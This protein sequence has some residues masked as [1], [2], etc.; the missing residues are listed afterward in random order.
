MKR[1]I[2][3]GLMCLATTANANTVTDVFTSFYSFGD[4][5]TDQGMFGTLPATPPSVGGRFTNGPTWA[6]NIAEVFEDAGR[7]T[8]NLAVGGA[9]AGNGGTFT[10]LSNFNGQIDTFLGSLAGGVPLPTQIFPV[11]ELEDTPAA[12]G[13]NPLVSV[14]LG[15]NDLFAGLDVPDILASIAGGGIGFD[16]AVVTD[17]ADAVVAGI[18]R[19]ATAPGSVFDDFLVANLPDLGATPAYA[20][21]LALN[22]FDTRTVAAISGAATLAT[23]MF[24]TALADNLDTLES[25]LDINLFEY[26][27]AAAF[28]EVI[29]DP[30]AFGFVS[31]TEPC[32]VSLNSATNPFVCDPSEVDLLVF[33]DAVHPNQV[34]QRLTSDRILVQLNAATA[35]A[36]V[37]LPASAPLLLLGAGALIAARR[38]KAA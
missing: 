9:T 23:D 38:R 22:G 11:V 33:I 26:D 15:A 19:L 27:A 12:P 17:A 34:A 32:T 31:A 28:A 10:P 24:N 14:W 5:L 2:A 21:L 20:S 29:A 37:P 30:S 13:S 8:G 4:S 3:A 16:P 1:I 36:P 7:D 18:E 35:P 6:E 25:T